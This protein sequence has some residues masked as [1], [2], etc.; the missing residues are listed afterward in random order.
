MN[1]EK[2]KM[3]IMTLLNVI[4]IKFIKR[5]PNQLFSKMI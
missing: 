2:E 4:L 3:V 5:F 1:I